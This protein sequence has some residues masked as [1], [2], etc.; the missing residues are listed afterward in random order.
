M[1]PMEVSGMT[2][3]QR[4]KQAI[5]KARLIARAELRAFMAGESDVLDCSGDRERQFIIAEIQ[6]A[7]DGTAGK[8]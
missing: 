8:H 4:Y 6:R 5:L 2:A 3:E 1:M 7:M